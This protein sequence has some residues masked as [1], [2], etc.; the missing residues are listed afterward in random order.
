MR[1]Y[2][3]DYCHEHK[4]VSNSTYGGIVKFSTM[5]KASWEGI[6]YLIDC[7]LCLLLQKLKLFTIYIVDPNVKQEKMKNRIE[8]TSFLHKKTANFSQSY[9]I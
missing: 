7:P 1:S 3:H 9:A 2:G 8:N 6:L 5:I 4:W